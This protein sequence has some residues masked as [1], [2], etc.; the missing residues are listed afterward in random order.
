MAIA[1]QRRR[2]LL[3][4]AGGERA[5]GGG[6]CRGRP[7]DSPETGCDAR[8]RR[9]TA[10]GP[11]RTLPDRDRELLALKYGAG[12][13]NRAIARLTGLSESNVGTIVHRAVQAL[14]RRGERENTMDDACLN[15]LQ[16]RAAG[17]SSAKRLRDR[18]RADRRHAGQR[19]LRSPRKILRVAAGGGRRRRAVHRAAG[20]RV[21][22]FA[23][24]AD[25]ASSTSSRCRSNPGATRRRRRRRLDLKA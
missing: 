22:R 25:S 10:G 4:R 11:A 14:R 15:R 16:K 17:S 13:T 21:I 8:I 1:R 23:P 12:M 5:A 6:E 19:E 24:G 2:R 9:G 7:A 3:P 18:L 20:P